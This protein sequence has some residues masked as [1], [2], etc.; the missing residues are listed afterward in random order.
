MNE[1]TTT[2]SLESGPASMTVSIKD[3]EVS[4]VVVGIPVSTF[5]DGR[6][7]YQ[8]LKRLIDTA[9]DQY[10]RVCDKND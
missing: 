6:T 4:I 8:D 1:I 9:V 3:W 2:H 10:I 7:A 5:D